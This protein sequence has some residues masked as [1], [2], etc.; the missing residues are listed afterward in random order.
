MPLPNTLQPRALAR[1]L[2]AA[3]GRA[4]KSEITLP[5]SNAPPPA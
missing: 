4:T 2:G 5:A 3:L 1:S